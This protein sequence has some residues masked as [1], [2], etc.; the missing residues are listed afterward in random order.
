MGE[1]KPADRAKLLQEQPVTLQIPNRQHNFQKRPKNFLQHPIKHPETITRIFQEQP[2]S[3]R[4]QLQIR[5]RTHPR[6]L[7]EVLRWRIC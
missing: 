3:L 1:T 6:N 2:R 7:A 5:P 4:R